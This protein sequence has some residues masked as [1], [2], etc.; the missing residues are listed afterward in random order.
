M[1]VFYRVADTEGVKIG[2]GQSVSGRCM[3][4]ARVQLAIA[5][6]PVC[7]V[8]VNGEVYVRENSCS[9]RPLYP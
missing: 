8:F 7:I 9:R 3:C 5:I 6:M 4:L 1:D 2:G